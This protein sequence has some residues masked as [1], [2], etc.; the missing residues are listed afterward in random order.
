[1]NW[2]GGSRNRFMMRNDMKKQREFFEKK[3]MQRKMK[4]LGIPTSPKGASS[5]SMDLVTLFIVNQIAAKKENNDQPKITHITDD[6]GGPKSMREGPLELPM[7]PCSPSR[8]SLVESQPLYSVQAARKRKHCIPDGFK[9]RQLSPVLESNMSDTSTS[10]YQQHIQDTLSPFCSASSSVSS[11]GAGLFSLQQRAQVQP[12]LHCSPRPPWDTATSAQLQFRPFSQPGGRRECSPWATG[13]SGPKQQLN[14]TPPVSRVRFGGT[15]PD[16]DTRD[17]VMHAVGF[18]INQSEGKDHTLEFSLKDQTMKFS[19]NQIESE[20]QHEKALFRACSNEEYGS[21]AANFKKGM[22]KIYLKEEV[23]TSSRDVNESQSQNPEPD[24]LTQVSNCTDVSSSCPGNTHHGPKECCESS[25]SYSPRRGYFSSDSD[26][27]EVE[28]YYQCHQG[29]TSQSHT[30]RSCSEEFN[31]LSQGSSHWNTQQLG[32]PQSQSRP[33]TPLTRSQSTGNC[34]NDQRDHRDQRAL[35][36]FG[37]TERRS[38]CVVADDSNGQVRVISDQYVPS[39]PLSESQCSEVHQQKIEAT[40]TRETQTREMGTQ[41]VANI[42]SKCPTSDVSTQCSFGQECKE[43]NLMDSESHKSAYN[44]IPTPTTRGQASHRDESM[45]Q[46]T[47]RALSDRSRREGEEQTP[48]R[49]ST[50]RELKAGPGHHPSIIPS[51]KCRNTNTESRVCIQRPTTSIL[52]TLLITN[53]VK[54]LRDE[55]LQ[56]RGQGDE[57]EVL[58]PVENVPLREDLPDDKEEKRRGSAEER[59]EVTAESGVNR[60]SEEVETLQEIAD[61]LLMLKQR[62]KD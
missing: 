5:G 54:D 42:T 9:C 30:V 35:E 61:I 41:T 16:T 46:Q 25:P 47:H 34:G 4:T 6:K 24:F 36:S 43:N 27:D 26:D 13:P 60:L 11:S 44:V 19:L 32:H 59:E 28:D 53:D 3:K 55:Q 57:R 39:C 52:D 45:R 40:G 2:V 1:M 49:K 18:S 14:M 15:E 17:H 51:N 23:P 58:D 56:H 10:D 31:V 62:K 8:L 21:E 7:S 33:Y 29:G 37:Y 12:Q 22:S 48:W 38:G 50:A 20:E